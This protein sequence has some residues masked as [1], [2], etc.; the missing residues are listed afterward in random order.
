MFVH[1]RGEREKGMLD[2]GEREGKVMVDIG[3]R[4]GEGDGGYRGERERGRR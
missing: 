3:E 1:H 4:E 2:I